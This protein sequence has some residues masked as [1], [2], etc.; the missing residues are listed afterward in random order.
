MMKTFELTGAEL[1]EWVARAIGLRVEK[2]FRHEV[3]GEIM[4]IVNEHEIRGVPR[5]STNWSDGGPII[6]SQFLS[7]EF[8]GF[9]PEAKTDDDDEIW[10]ATYTGN[11]GALVDGL[12]PTP[13]IAAM[14]AYV[15]SKF[16]DEVIDGGESNGI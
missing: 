4:Q 7:L 9:N 3:N 6:K 10:Q 12:G 15:A 8:V 16:G 14:R 2:R 13:L 5:Y 1:D 11:N